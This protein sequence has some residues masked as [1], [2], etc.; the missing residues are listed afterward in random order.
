[1]TDRTI[2]LLVTLN[3]EIRTDDVEKIIDAIK[4]IKHVGDVDINIFTCK[5]QM[6]AHSAKLLWVT[7][8]SKEIYRLLQKVISSKDKI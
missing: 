5:D 2:S 3:E 6:N 4:M 1:M 8:L 7:D